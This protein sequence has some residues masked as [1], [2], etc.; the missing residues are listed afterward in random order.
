MGDSITAGEADTNRLGY[1]G[2][3][4]SFV[5]PG[6]NV[7][8]I[9]VGGENT[10]RGRS[11]L[12]R[13]FDNGA[14]RQFEYV[15]VLEGINDYFDDNHSAANTRS[16]LFTML[17]TASNAGALSFLGSLTQ[18]KRQTSQKSWVTAV[19]SQIRGNVKIDFYTLGTGIVS[20]DKLHPNGPGYQRMAELAAVSLR[21]YSEA[22]RP[23]DLDHDGIYDFAEARFGTSPS[24][25][26]GDADG[27]LDGEEVFTYHTNPALT[28]SDGDGLSD[29]EEAVVRHTNPLSPL[30]TAPT[31]TTIQAIP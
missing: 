31:I 18:I 15:I 29:Y 30:P 16:N 20:G 7:K 17:R 13:F 1:P 9:G 12:A 19:N 8:N 22:S 10:S 2:R 21:A 3:L 25:A 6:S 26:D 4:E 14:N 23:A 11:R 28:D 27:L 5:L 24:V